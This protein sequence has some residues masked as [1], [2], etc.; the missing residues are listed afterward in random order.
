MRTWF[1]LCT[2]LTRAQAGGTDFMRLVSFLIPDRAHHGLINDFISIRN[3]MAHGRAIPDPIQGHHLDTLL[4]RFAHRAQS[5]WR[6]DIAVPISMTYDGSSYRVE[7]LK[8]SGTGTPNPCAIKDTSPIV[9]S[10]WCLL[11]TSAKP[12]PLAPWL[13]APKTDDPAKLHCLLFDGLQYMKGKPVADTPFKYSST[14]GA[15]GR[16]SAPIQSGGT[17]QALAPG[18]AL[19]VRSNPAPQRS[20]GRRARR[21]RAAD[22]SAGS[23]V[24][25]RARRR[26]FEDADLGQ[27]G[28]S[29]CDLVSVD[30]HCDWRLCSHI[31]TKA[32]YRTGCSAT[33]SPEAER[34][35]EGV[36]GWR[37]GSSATPSSTR[38]TA[39]ARHFAFDNDG[40]TTRSSRAAG[41]APTSCRFPGHA[42]AASS[43]SS[44]SPN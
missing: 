36:V 31:R 35:C 29:P 22:T 11:S 44:S 12:L 7:V 8:L 41:Q 6:A 39:P 25:G 40:I 18:R 32:S 2:A 14:Y 34:K 33:L 30:L 3:G 5:A 16:G 24:A 38:R 19:R 17:W 15:S 37:T 10:N 27:A 9:T 26:G 21:A 42:S 20:R 4:R 23:V 28:S 13:I 1:D 43:S